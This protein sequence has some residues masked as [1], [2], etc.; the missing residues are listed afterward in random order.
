MLVCP[1]PRAGFTKIKAPFPSP[2]GFSQRF[3]VG[4]SADQLSDIF[5]T[6][7]QFNVPLGGV[8]IAFLVEGHLRKTMGLCRVPKKQRSI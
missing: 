2:S 7:S 3:Q 1:P 4:Q 6:L 5:E 8:Y